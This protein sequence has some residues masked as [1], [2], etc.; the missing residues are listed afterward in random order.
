VAEW[1]NSYLGWVCGSG[2][3]Y[4]G[5]D[6]GVHATVVIYTY[7]N[8]SDLWHSAVTTSIITEDHTPCVDESYP[9]CNH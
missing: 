7:R 2:L 8:L 6:F 4:L 9:A 3:D 1:L 5:Q